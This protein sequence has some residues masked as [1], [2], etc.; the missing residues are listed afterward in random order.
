MKLTDFQVL[1]F[2]CYG[3]LIDWETGILAALQPLLE[4]A[5]LKPGAD[6]DILQ[7][8]GRHEAAQEAATPQFLYPDILAEVHSRLA[9]DWGVPP[10]GAQA[11]A[12]GASVPAWPPFPDSPGA[13]AYLKTHY[14]LVIL[15]NVDRHSFKGSE[16]TLG[17]D[18]DYVFTAEDIGSYKPS[19][20]NFDYLIDRLAD[21]GFPKE[22]ILHTAQSLF[23]DHVPANHAG[24]RTAW[25]N[26]RSGIGSSGATPIPDNMPHLDFEFPTLEALARAHRSELASH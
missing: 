24:L 25:I 2:D 7:A 21:R 9:K 15:S 1:S 4:R 16:S 3:T 11:R 5:N 8:F 14:T 13:L 17:I 6:D 10:D 20:R 26:R 19:P 18:F 23:H 22:T 12:F